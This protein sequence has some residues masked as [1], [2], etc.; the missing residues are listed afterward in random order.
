M[1]DACH[2][3]P[4]FLLEL[5]SRGQARC[6]SA[7]VKRLER[8]ALAGC[9]APSRSKRAG[10]SGW[11]AAGVNAGKASLHREKGRE[12]S[13]PSLVNRGSSVLSPRG[14]PGGQNTK[15]ER[16]VSILASK[17]SNKIPFVKYTR[18]R[19]DREPRLGVGLRCGGQGAPQPKR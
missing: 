11:G 3:Q 2:T 17:Y 4:L 5:C 1:I 12:G 10:T 14:Q 9:S 18:Q 19:D 16:M 6:S 8:A 13:L 7:V 15:K